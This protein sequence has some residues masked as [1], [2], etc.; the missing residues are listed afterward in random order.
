MLV[1]THFIA[2]H[3]LKPLARYLSIDDVITGAKKVLKGLAVE[4]KPPR[5]LPGIRF[6]KIR[7]GS[8]QSARMMV[9]VS[10]KNQNIFPLVIRLKKDKISGMNMAMNNPTMFKQ[11]NKNLDEVLADI[12]ARRYQEFEL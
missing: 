9:F 7:L 12:E 8:R 10:I 1:L 6:F 3:E 11:I 5:S 4:T 2:N